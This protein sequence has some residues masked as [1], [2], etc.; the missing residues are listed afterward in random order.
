MQQLALFDTR[1]L[2]NFDFPDYKKVYTVFAYDE[3]KAHKFYK[4]K[5]PSCKINV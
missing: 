1:Y 2:T 3:I 5:K 4:K